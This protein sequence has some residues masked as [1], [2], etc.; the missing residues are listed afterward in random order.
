MIKKFIIKTNEWY[1]S[2]PT[3]KGG[4]FY[5]GLIFIPYI[6]LFLSISP[7]WNFLSLLWPFSVAMW[8][9][10]YNAIKEFQGQK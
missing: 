5:I 3:T 10:S 1:E 6:I 9:F 4:L 8:R 2:L 7:E